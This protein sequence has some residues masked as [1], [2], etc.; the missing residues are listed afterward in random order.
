MLM[1]ANTLSLLLGAAAMIVSRL[2]DLLGGLHRLVDL[3]S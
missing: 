2:D 3:V 1:W